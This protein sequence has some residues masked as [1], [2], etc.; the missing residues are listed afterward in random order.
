VAATAETVTVRVEAAGLRA[1]R[2]LDAWFYP[3]AWG[4]IDFAADQTLT[5]SADALL[6]R[7]ARG[8]LPEATQ[9]PAEGVL[10]ITERLDAGPAT[11]PLRCAPTRRGSGAGDGRGLLVGA[12][13]VLALALVGG[14][15]LNA[16]PCVLPVLSVKALALTHHGDSRSGMR[17]HGLAYTAGILVAFAVLAADCCS[18]ARAES[19]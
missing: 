17:A 9:R 18:C 15:I 1:D 13:S 12:P 8:P 3:L 11:Q 7:T 2:I 19:V 4:L 6:L 16:M 14:I 10:V 5:V